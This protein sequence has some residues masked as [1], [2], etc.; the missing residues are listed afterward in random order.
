MNLMGKKKSKTCTGSKV[1]YVAA[2]IVGIIAIALLVDNIILFKNNVAQYVAQGYPSA[3]VL[4]QLIPAQLLPGI[5]EPLALYLGIALV[6]WGL[7][8]INQKVSICLTPGN[9]Q[10][11]MDAAK[12]PQEQYQNSLETEKT[13]ETDV[14]EPVDNGNES[15][16]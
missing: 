16:A 1:L 6:L 3:E 15:Q 10:L 5:F 11:T 12:E 7:G 14:N 9:D 2:A 4:K 8:A 13:N